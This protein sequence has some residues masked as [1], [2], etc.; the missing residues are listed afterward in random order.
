MVVLIWSEIIDA[1]PTSTN[2]NK[3]DLTFDP[4]IE[5]KNRSVGRVSTKFLTDLRIAASF[6]K[7]GRSL[8]TG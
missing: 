2:P 4:K 7:M 3:L 1:V 5:L 6:L 8:V